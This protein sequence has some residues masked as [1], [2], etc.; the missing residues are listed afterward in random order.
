MITIAHMT[1][2]NSGTMGPI[3]MALAGVALFFSRGIPA[4]ISG[5]FLVIASVCFLQE[6]LQ[7]LLLDSRNLIGVLIT[8]IIIIA[9]VYLFTRASKPP[10]DTPNE[11]DVP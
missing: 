5:G 6:Q 4:K 10:S 9:F 7:E 1:E 8:T 2:S 11:G 3:F